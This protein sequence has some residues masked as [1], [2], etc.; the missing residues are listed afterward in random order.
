M[1]L[2]ARL[3]PWAIGLTCRGLKWV[4]LQDLLTSLDRF[5]LRRCRGQIYGVKVHLNPLTVYPWHSHLPCLI[6]FMWKDPTLSILKSL[7]VETPSPLQ[8]SFWFNEEQI[9]PPLLIDIFSRIS[10]HF[11]IATSLDTALFMWSL[12]VMQQSNDVGSIIHNS[13]V[14][15]HFITQFPHSHQTRSTADDQQ[16]ERKRKNAS[17]FKCDVMDAAFEAKNV[18]CKLTISK[19]TQQ[20]LCEV[21]REGICVLAT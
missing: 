20:H 21:E 18:F 4:L 9:P 16:L 12:Q 8:I 7:V 19:V 17:E 10:I 1:T 2:R 14:R 3:C 15:W 6:P 5:T 11:L 13:T